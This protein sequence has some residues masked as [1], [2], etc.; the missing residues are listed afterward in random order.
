[1]DVV[2][3]II[4]LLLTTLLYVFL[5]AV[6]LVLWRD[7][8]ASTDLPAAI[9]ERK[10][11]LVV[12]NACDGLEPGTAFS[13]QPFTTLGRN[14]ANA[15]VVPDT[16]AS[17]EHALVSWRGG[18]WWLEDLG[19]R[20][21]TQINDALVTAPTVLGAGDVISIGQVKLKFEISNGKV[22]ISNTESRSHFEI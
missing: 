8:R 20:N 5:G 10:A 6:L 15:I 9:Q 4:R 18:Q 13:L 12:L 22:Q 1:M 2:I 11:R 16:F 17:A 14:A 19:S 3:F 21:G 7:L